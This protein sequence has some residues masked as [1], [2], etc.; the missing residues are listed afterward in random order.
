M[1]LMN[2]S[3]RSI[4]LMVLTHRVYHWLKLGYIGRIHAAQD[5][6]NF[7]EI[8]LLAMEVACLLA[9]DLKFVQC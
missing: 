2:P 9:K 8:H 6:N 1:C 7:D 5:A 4:L 3:R